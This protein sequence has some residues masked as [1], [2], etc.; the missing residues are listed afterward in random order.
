MR[1]IINHEQIDKRTHTN[2]HVIH[3]FAL[4]TFSSSPPDTKYII[5][6]SIRAITAITA[7][8]CIANAMSEETN[9]I[10]VEREEPP[11]SPHPGK[12]PQSIGGAANTLSHSV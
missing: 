6:L 7:T 5:P 2:D 3:V 10:G 9:E 8:Y 4:F 12:F 1:L 11:L